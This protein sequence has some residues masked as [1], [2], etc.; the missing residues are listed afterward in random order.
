MSILEKLQFKNV[1]FLDHP[2]LTGDK[3][4]KLVKFWASG[5]L[6]KAKNFAKDYISVF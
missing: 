3:C 2:M 6:Y 4:S 1:V 5:K